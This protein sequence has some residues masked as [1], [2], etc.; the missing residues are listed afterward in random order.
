MLVT[1]FD[2]VYRYCM[3][4]VEEDLRSRSDESCRSDREVPLKLSDDVDPDL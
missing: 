4:C 2:Y 1:S 3:F